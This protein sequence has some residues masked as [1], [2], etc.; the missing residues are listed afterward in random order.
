MSITV[1][2]VVSELKSLRKGRGLDAPDIVS[3]VG[4]ALRA[5]FDLGQEENS[6][7]VREKLTGDLKVFVEHLPDDLAQAVSMA[8]GLTGGSRTRLY[9]ER[10]VLLAQ[11]MGRDVRTAN[12]RVDDG[13]KVIAEAAVA[14]IRHDPPAPTNPWRTT[15]LRTSVVLDGAAAEVYEMRRITSLVPGLEEVVLEVS[16]PA[17]PGWDGITQPDDPR[18]TVLR[19]GTLHARLNH[20][21]SRIAFA[22]ALARPLDPGEEHDFFVRVEFSGKRT[23]GPFYVC[24]PSFPC[25]LFDLH[26]RFGKDRLPAA[27]WQV[28]GLRMSEVGDRAAPRTPVEVDAAGEVSARFTNLTPNLSFGLVWEELPE[29]P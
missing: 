18:I 19:G 12:R 9:R 14:R 15:A 25:E 20:S 29:T 11:E 16:T 27:V 13:L 8:Y 28:N 24:T 2:E 22:L 23:M 6:A 21:S 3:R 26:V 5:A 10:V 4:P 7:R 1:A 17:P